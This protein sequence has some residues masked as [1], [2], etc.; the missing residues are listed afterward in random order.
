MM[1]VENGN[2]AMTC[3]KIAL[4]KRYIKNMSHHR[5]TALLADGFLCMAVEIGKYT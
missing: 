4:L 3:D 1:I 5:P 2:I